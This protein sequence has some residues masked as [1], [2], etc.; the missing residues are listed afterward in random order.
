MLLFNMGFLASK[1]Y[2]STTQI[3]GSP[4]SL[5]AMILDPVGACFQR[6]ELNPFDW[7]EPPPEKKGDELKV[8]AEVED[9]PRNDSSPP[10][11][12]AIPVADC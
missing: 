11:P 7:Q 8:A 3:D 5:L 6:A 12:V 1:L 4:R 2:W 10:V 9:L